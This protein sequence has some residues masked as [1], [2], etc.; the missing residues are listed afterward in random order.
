MTTHHDDKQP[1][2]D[3]LA[4]SERHLISSYLAG[5]GV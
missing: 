5:A 1:T 2:H 4:E 3:P